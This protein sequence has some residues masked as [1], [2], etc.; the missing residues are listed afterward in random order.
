MALSGNFSYKKTALYKYT[1]FHKK[2]ICLLFEM[3]EHEHSQQWQTYHLFLLG[4]VLFFKVQIP[5]K[6]A[7]V[8]IRR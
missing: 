4:R 2:V 3:E 5:S 8:Y 7:N 1:F 6:L